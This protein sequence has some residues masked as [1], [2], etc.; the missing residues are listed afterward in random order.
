MGSESRLK[1]LVLDLMESVEAIEN[2][3]EEFVKREEFESA[4]DH[5]KIEIARIQGLLSGRSDVNLNV[6]A[7]SVD[8][9]DQSTKNYG[10]KK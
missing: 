2:I 5:I 3:K 6:K 7:N 9:I 10:E 8:T 4:L 1:V